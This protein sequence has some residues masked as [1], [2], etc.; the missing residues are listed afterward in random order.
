MED[1]ASEIS[2]GFFRALGF[3]LA[4]VFFWTICYWLG[5]PVC[6]VVSLGKYPKETTFFILGNHDDKGF[7]C[8]FTGLIVLVLLALVFLGV[9]G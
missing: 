2:N 4:E 5:W 7:W 3:L 6:K 9:F 8:A 1:V